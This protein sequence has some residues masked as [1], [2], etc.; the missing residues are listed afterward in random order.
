[1]TVRARCLSW[2]LSAAVLSP[3]AGLHGALAAQEF[4]ATPGATPS[5]TRVRDGN[6]RRAALMVAALQAY[7]EEGAAIGGAGVVVAIDSAVWIVTARHVVAAELS[8]AVPFVL[9]PRV[10]V[11]LLLADGRRVTLPGRPSLLDSAFLADLRAT[12]ERVSE[13]DSV[14]DVA[15]RLARDS[16]LIA[17]YDLA[18]VRV[19]AALAR[20]RGWVP[21]RLDRL[22]SVGDLVRGD[23]VTP[24][25]C[26]GG[27]CWELP[28]RGDRFQ[29]AVPRRTRLAGALQ[30]QSLSVTNGNSGG[31]LFDRLFELVG[32]V[33]NTEGALVEAIPVDEV[34]MVLRR[35]GLPVQWQRARYPRD[36]YRAALQVDALT[37]PW[38]AST[39][40]SL[41]DGTRL[42]SVRAVWSSRGR[43]AV[44]W[45]AGVLR[46]A[47]SR[48]ALHGAI[49]GVE[50]G[51]R[52]PRFAM[53][54]HAD[55]GLG[56][57]A[58]RHDRQGY[59]LTTNGRSVY[60]PVWA[61]EHASSTIVGGGAV[62]TWLV[63]PRTALA[64]SVTR[65][66]YGT[67]PQAPDVP[68]LYTGLGVRWHP[69]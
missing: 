55:L 3:A 37:A 18:V 10:E 66:N 15:E 62:L 28:P 31:A 26:P 1:M 24:L 13:P 51:V 20:S 16:S 42:P 9:H 47:P 53:T 14:R 21:A 27:R 49:A 58:A 65:W 68:H 52:T 22:G 41:P 40:D 7:P 17:S 64:L 4:V 5:I 46:L 2:L 48:V 44:G 29:E 34:T 12:R 59:W 50:Y 54:V 57:V 33:V 11:G 32:V 61:V 63:Q 45:H 19:D 30:F 8:G 56:Q 25:G 43:R 69:R 67:T 35:A 23:E 6:A 36:G 39:P 60:Q 38:A